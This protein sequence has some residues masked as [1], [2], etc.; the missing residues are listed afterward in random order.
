MMETDT[1][2]DCPFVS[3][4]GEVFIGN[5]LHWTHLNWRG[6][7]F[8]NSK[9]QSNPML[10]SSTSAPTIAIKGLCEHCWRY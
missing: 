10:T 8:P 6:N 5:T 4:V 7:F 9:R 2:S 1:H 3:W